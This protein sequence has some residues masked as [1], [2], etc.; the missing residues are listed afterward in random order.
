MPERELR[1]TVGIGKVSEFLFGHG[2]KFGFQIGSL[3]ERIEDPYFNDLKLLALLSQNGMRVPESQVSKDLEERI[4]RRIAKHINEGRINQNYVYDYYNVTSLV[5]FVVLELKRTGMALR[6]S[7]T[8]FETGDIW[9]IVQESKVP[10]NLAGLETEEIRSTIDASIAP[11]FQAILSKAETE[12]SIPCLIEAL[13]SRFTYRGERLG[14]K[15]ESREVEELLE[16][17]EYPY[18]SDKTRWVATY[19]VNLNTYQVTIFQAINP[20]ADSAKEALVRIRTS[21]NN[22]KLDKEIDRYLKQYKYPD[23]YPRINTQSTAENWK[24]VSS[25]PT[26]RRMNRAS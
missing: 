8:D 12:M 14:V 19:G 18:G 7:I 17:G 3:S 22:P 10:D 11:I 4:I 5:D 1:A 23:K 13:K 21:S 24:L 2:R 9:T 6:Q 25:Q 26:G 16:E 20:L 15:E